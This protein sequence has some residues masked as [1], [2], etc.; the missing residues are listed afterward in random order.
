[1][2]DRRRASS[3]YEFGPHFT[4]CVDSQR[5]VIEGARQIALEPGIL[6]CNGRKA[7]AHS[8]GC[9]RR[10]QKEPRICTVGVG[11]RAGGDGTA[12]K[13]RPGTGNVIDSKQKTIA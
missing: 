13:R 12:A 8:L 9:L 4:G 3:A 2:D 6:C 1:M 11:S 7:L 10:Q 5:H